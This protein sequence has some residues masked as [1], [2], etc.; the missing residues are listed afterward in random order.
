[1]WFFTWQDC[2]L[3]Y[4]T[5]NQ[6]TY[7]DRPFHSQCSVYQG[8]LQVRCCCPPA[9]A[10]DAAAASPHTMLPLL[11]TA[12]PL[13]AEPFLKPPQART[14]S[15][16]SCSS[17]LLCRALAQATCKCSAL[18]RNVLRAL[19]AELRKLQEAYVLFASDPTAW[20]EYYARGH[21]KLG[22][23]GVKYSDLFPGGVRSSLLRV[24]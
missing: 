7:C 21:C 20:E 5:R 13:P 14:C 1:M 12:A 9:A 24:P 2:D 18:F 23:Q 11:A 3:I 4:S 22:E 19:Q 15:G 8:D 6:D 16:C 17:G 10:S